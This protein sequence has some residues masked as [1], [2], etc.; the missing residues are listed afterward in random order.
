MLAFTA[1]HIN[2]LQALES[3]RVN[4]SGSENR[5][6]VVKDDIY[7]IIDKSRVFIR[8]ESQ[9]ADEAAFRSKPSC[10]VGRWDNDEL[11]GSLGYVSEDEEYD[12]LRCTEMSDVT[13]QFKTDSTII[14]EETENNGICSDFKYTYLP[15]MVHHSV[16]RVFDTQVLVMGG[17]DRYSS[18]PL[19]NLLFF[20]T[21]TLTWSHVKATGKAPTQLI[22]HHA[23]PLTANPFSRFVAVVGGT[24]EDEFTGIE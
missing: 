22:N 5:L 10:T 1:A 20:D 15:K 23:A 2:I 19:T 4:V 6:D 3:Q 16:T 11:A 9:A 21:Q 8:P 17:R 18:T 12:Y 24:V 14:S 7:R 13:D